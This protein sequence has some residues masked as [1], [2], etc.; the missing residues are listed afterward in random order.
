[1]IEENKL[2]ADTISKSDNVQEIFYNPF[3]TTYHWNVQSID[4]EG[5]DFQV[6]KEVVND[7][8]QTVDPKG[9]RNHQKKDNPAVLFN[10]A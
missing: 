10:P 7:F 2:L 9:C 6:A 8:D 5:A 1:V 3:I 4:I